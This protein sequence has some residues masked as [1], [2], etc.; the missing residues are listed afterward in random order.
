MRFVLVPL[1]GSDLA[2]AAVVMTSHGRTGV[3][4]ALV[5][6]V[7]NAR[8]HTLRCPIVVIPLL[9]TMGDV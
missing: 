8:M 1:D 9:A 3:S 2:A 5:G 7:V 4:R 6:G